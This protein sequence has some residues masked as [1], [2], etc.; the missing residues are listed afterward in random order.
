MTTVDEYFDWLC[1]KINVPPVGKMPYRELAWAL[2][3]VQFSP[4]REEMDMNRAFDGLHLRSEFVSK[5]GELGSSGNRGPCTFL[6]MMI[7]LAKRMAFL[8][9][10]KEK[11]R[12]VIEFF[13]K[14][15]ENLG[16]SGFDDVHFSA[17]HGDRVVAKATDLVMSREYLPDGQGGLF[18]VRH[19]KEDMRAVELWYQMHA[20]LSENY[21]SEIL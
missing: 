21:G 9:E 12:R 13:W 1:K 14:M 4:G 18:P 8:M 3:H 20:W 17:L 2:Y 15:V 11:P 19:P 16:L 7:G 5:H 6:E 10:S